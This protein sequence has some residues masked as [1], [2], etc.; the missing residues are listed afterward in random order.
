VQADR[1]RGGLGDRPGGGRDRAE[2]A[3]VEAD[4]VLADLWDLGQAG[5]LG[6]GHDRLRVLDGDD[7]ERARAAA[8]RPGPRDDLAGGCV[9]GASSQAA[10]TRTAGSRRR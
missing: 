3:V 7:V 1:H 5:L 9:Q 2:P 6:A 4:G 10:L 8:G